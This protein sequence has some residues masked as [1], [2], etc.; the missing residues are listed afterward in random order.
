MAMLIKIIKF[1][2]RFTLSFTAI[3]YFFRSLFWRRLKPE[4]RGQTWLV[5]GASGGLGEAIVAQAV[6]AGALVLAV[7]RNAAKLEALV[8]RHGAGVTPMAADLSSQRDTQR[9]IDDLVRSGRKIDVLVN[10]VGVLLN[11]FALTPEGRE[12]SFATNI[13]NHFLLTERL[14]EA[15]V[16]MNDAVVINMSSGGMYN[17]PLMVAKMNVTDPKRYAG[18]FAYAVHKRGQAELTKYWTATYGPRGMKFY[19]MHPGWADTEGVERSLPRFHKILKAILRD[20]RQGTETAIWLAAT[21]PDGEPGGFW[22]DRKI[23]TSHVYPA[24]MVSKDTPAGL[25]DYLRKELATLA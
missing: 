17:A 6:A 23:R 19:V 11:G 4:F 18:V 9:L 20:G 1:Y 14:I 10:N 12:M 16:L 5:T 21:K 25:A 3:G 22:F 2:G 15:S 13:L 24:T 7:A 8:K